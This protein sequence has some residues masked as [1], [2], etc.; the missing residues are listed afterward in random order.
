MHESDTTP[1]IKEVD[2]VHHG[3]VEV[4]VYKRRWW[5]LFIFGSLG[6]MQCAVWNTWGPITATAKSAYGWDDAEIALLSTWGTLT[7][8]IGLVP[9]TIFLQKKGLGPSI[10]ITSILIALATG[11]RCFTIDAKSFTILSH[12]GA[13]LNGFAGIIIAIAP[14]LLSSTWFPPHERTTATGVGCTMNQLGNLGGF[15]LGPLLVQEP[16]NM[17]EDFDFQHEFL[18]NSVNV[19]NGL[20]PEVEAMRKSIR[21][22]MWIAAGVCISFL[23]FTLVYFPS[24]PP[25][26]PS[27][28]SASHNEE[29]KDKPFMEHLN[30]IKRNGNF[31]LLFLPYAVTLG[32]NVA[33]GSILDINLLPFG[34]SQEEA[35]W[36]GVY[37]NVGGVLLAMIAARLTDLLFGH[38]KKTI[39]GLMIVA[40]LSFTWFLLLMN[41]VL[42]FD[43]VQMYISVIMGASFNYAVSP[44]FFELAVELAYPVPEGVVGGFLTFG[45]NVVAVM[46]LLVLQL[47]VDGVLWMDY[48]LAIQ[49]AVV[50]V[51]VLFVKEEYR[52]TSLDQN[53]V[54]IEQ[55]RESSASRISSAASGISNA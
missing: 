27:L 9:M 29:D 43:K 22:Y 55:H 40:T 49:G 47:K 45:Y 7:I 20:D 14:S 44:L 12:L 32:I 1:I 52:R 41:G 38:I 17:T 48:I 13:I 50:V 51:L 18:Y 39:L 5:I 6:F 4:Q 3:E 31:W 24:K 37:T 34:I 33:W 28:S 16:L 53:V 25:K 21:V 11:I 36:V 26:P 23:V 30:D 15:I 42:P 54:V 2:G 46:F 8:L 19:T 10:L 35:S